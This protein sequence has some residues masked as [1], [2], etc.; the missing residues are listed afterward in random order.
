MKCGRVRFIVGV[1]LVVTLFM[2][3][4]GCTAFQTRILNYGV[5]TFFEKGEDALIRH[6]LEIDCDRLAN[7]GIGGAA[8][9]TILINNFLGDHKAINT[10]NSLFYAAYG[11]LIEYEDLKH[12]MY[13]YK[14]SREYGMTAL[15]TNKKFREGLEKGIKIHK[16]V[17]Y[18][19]E[20]YKGP[21]L[22]TALGW[23]MQVMLGPDDM[24]ELVNMPDIIAM[25]DRSIELD[26][27]YLYGLGLT[28]KGAYYAFVPE[29]IGLGGGPESS[30]ATFDKA[31]KVSDGMVFLADTFRARYWAT[32]MK[33]EEM[34]DILLNKTV[35]LP[36]NYFR[37]GTLLNELA[38]WKAGE[39]L[40]DK[41]EWF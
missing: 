11:I 41:Y 30:K 17:H 3:V 32:L 33:D 26:E 8:L 12:A 19:G 23:G 4:S 16:L 31:K 25:V 27:E 40:R 13:L 28:F 2:V 7:D 9:I 24:F 18:L 15:K 5:E 36:R 37:E 29:F 20:E 22:F 21:L 6:I 14:K 38:R 35:E 1:F 39:Y 34:F 10:L